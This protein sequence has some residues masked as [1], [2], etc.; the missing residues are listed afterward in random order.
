[1]VSN[2]WPGEVWW[3]WE[4]RSLKQPDRGII[5]KTLDVKWSQPTTER[6]ANDPMHQDITKWL[7]SDGM[8]SSE[9]TS[10]LVFLH[11][12]HSFATSFPS[13]YSLARA[14][15]N[16]FSGLRNGSEWDSNCSLTISRQATIGLSIKSWFGAF[17]P[18]PI[19][20][21]PRFV[22]FGQR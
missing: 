18:W 3:W 7:V 15:L 21:S 10:E 13:L 11:L 5:Q 2:E 9:W 8:V 20:I 19:V 14:S 1:M 4:R 22:P 16:P 17:W 12:L 6:L